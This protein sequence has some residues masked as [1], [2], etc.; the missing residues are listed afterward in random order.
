MK[1]WLLIISAMILSAVV[2]DLGVRFITWGGDFSSITND[3]RGAV[4]F[5]FV[6]IS[7]VFWWILANRYDSCDKFEGY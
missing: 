2:C 7:L 4:L 1:G 5:I 6:V 3:Q